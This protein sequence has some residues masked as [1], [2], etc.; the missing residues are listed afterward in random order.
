MTPGDEPDLPGAVGESRAQRLG[1]ALRGLAADVVNERQKVTE[2]RRSV[3]ELTSRLEAVQGTQ[4]RDQAQPVAPLEACPPWARWNG[5][6]ER[7]YTLGV[8]E[9]LMLLERGS[10]S[11]AQ[12]SDRVLARLSDELSLRASPETH[13]GV[14]ELT[15][16]IHTNVHRVMGE[17][18]ALRRR[19]AREVGAMGLSAAGG[20][21]VPDDPARRDSRLRRRALPPARRLVALARASRADDGVARPRG[22]ARCRGRHPT[23]QWAPRQRADPDRP[24]GEL[25]V[26]AGARRRLRLHAHGHLPGL[27]AHRAT[28]IASPATPTTWTRSMP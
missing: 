22:R 13:A 14:I 9:E 16:G 7:R 5:E 18:A 6:L 1:S 27:P 24:V 25:P 11:L 23:R 2:L 28:A 21:R 10:S 19:L 17:L 20:G 15:T 3:A 4:S 8:E 26:L 12:S